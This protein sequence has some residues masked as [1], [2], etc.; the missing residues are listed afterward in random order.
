MSAAVWIDLLKTERVLFESAIHYYNETIKC[1]IGLAL[2]ISTYLGEIW[3]ICLQLEYEGHAVNGLCV[4]AVYQFIMD[5][6]SLL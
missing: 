3:I 5:G 2:D 4:C 1:N 6:V